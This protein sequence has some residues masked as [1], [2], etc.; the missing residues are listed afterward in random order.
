MATNIQIQRMALDKS[1]LV[2]ASGLRPP[3]LPEDVVKRFPS[4]AGYQQQLGEY[5]NKMDKYFTS[6]L[7]AVKQEDD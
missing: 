5:F 1:A 3:T 2:E 4:M 7:I 6:Q